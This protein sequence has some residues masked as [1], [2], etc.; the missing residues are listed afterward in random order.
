MK[1]GQII[2]DYTGINSF[3]Y[4]THLAKVVDDAAE[5]IAT[6]AAAEAKTTKKYPQW[7]VAKPGTWSRDD[8][9][10]TM[11]MES[12]WTESRHGRDYRWRVAIIVQHPTRAGRAAGRT[13]LKFAMRNRSA[14]DRARIRADRKAKAAERRA[15]RLH[16]QDIAA[17]EAARDATL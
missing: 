15:A 12:G 10:P 4:N 6:D 14:E 13:A 17:E 7:V 8:D 11:R 2:P 1:N 5:A 16:D 3:L 9:K